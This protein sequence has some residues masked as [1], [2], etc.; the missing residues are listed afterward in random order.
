MNE[1]PI[2]F[3]EH[4]V[5]A[6]KEHKCC[7][8]RKPIRRGTLYLRSSGIWPDGPDSYKTCLRCHKIRGRAIKAMPDWYSEDEGPAFG[9]LFDWIRESLCPSPKM[10]KP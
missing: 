2:A 3:D 8:F 10:A 7:E 1:L 9:M 4:I 5:K 6:R